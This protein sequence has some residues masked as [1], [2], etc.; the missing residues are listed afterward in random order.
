MRASVLLL[1]L[2]FA[3]AA[4][5]PAMGASQSSSD[6][7]KSSVPA[8]GGAGA[9]PTPEIKCKV[10]VYDFNGNPLLTENDA[11]MLYMR[12]NDWLDVAIA[13]NMS[14]YS[15]IPITFFLSRIKSGASWASIVARIGVPP[16][17]AF[18]VAGYPFGHYSIYSQSMQ[19]KRMDRICK[20][21][22]TNS[23]QPCAPPMLNPTQ[24]FKSFYY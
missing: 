21:Q 12:G 17:L 3:L 20:F 16:K 7:E 24:P 11:N 22:D 4:A 19:D 14:K 15:G 5:V 8:S 1:A 23:L 2:A 18:N 6:I 10:V 9:V 13:T